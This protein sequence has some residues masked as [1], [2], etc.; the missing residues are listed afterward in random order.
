MAGVRGPCSNLLAG[1]S[2]TLSQYYTKHSSHIRHITR[3]CKITA[4]ACVLLTPTERHS[5]IDR[6]DISLSQHKALLPV[7]PDVHPKR[8]ITSFLC[9]DLHD[10]F[11]MNATASLCGI[12]LCGTSRTS[13][14]ITPNTKGFC[15]TLRSR[16]NVT[17]PA[18]PTHPLTYP[19]TTAYGI[20][21]PDTTNIPYK[22]CLEF[23]QTDVEYS[24]HVHISRAP[25]LATPPQTCDLIFLVAFKE[26]PTQL[27][28]DV[29]ISTSRYTQYQYHWVSRWLT[30]AHTGEK[31]KGERA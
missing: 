27:E 25:D 17:A 11:D 6:S 7:L 14:I 26:G 21:W 19:Q 23:M 5:H 30:H 3:N 2:P 20:H 28:E 24:L 10:T 29:N 13:L 16:C 31:Q 4:Q 22:S 1:I 8:C 18:I 15:L 9:T 12:L